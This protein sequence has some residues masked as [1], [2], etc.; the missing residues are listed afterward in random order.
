MALLLLANCC[1]LQLRYKINISRVYII[2]LG[3]REMASDQRLSSGVAFENSYRFILWRC[4]KI[5]N[6]ERRSL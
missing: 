5:N 2:A 4:E 6:V 3:L 1:N